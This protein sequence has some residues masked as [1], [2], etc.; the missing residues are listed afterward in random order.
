MPRKQLIAQQRLLRVD[1]RSNTEDGLSLK[2]STKGKRR[3]SLS[4]SLSQISRQ[5]LNLAN[6]HLRLSRSTE[7]PTPP[8][9]TMHLSLFENAF[10]YIAESKRGIYEL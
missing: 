9:A 2:P 7:Q 6:K 1:V 4:G 5:G 10:K 3:K 8:V